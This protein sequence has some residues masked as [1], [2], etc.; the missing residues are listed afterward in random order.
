MYTTIVH[1]QVLPEFIDDFIQASRDNHFGSVAEVGNL[2]FDILQDPM[3]KSRFIL[4][5]SYL[6]E[7]HAQAHKKTTHYL[8]WRDTVANWMATPRRGETFVMLLPE[9][10]EEK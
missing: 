10:F 9:F 3:D 5:E 4:Y 2:R 6:S 1:V 8:R 7:A